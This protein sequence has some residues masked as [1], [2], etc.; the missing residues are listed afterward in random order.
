MIRRY[1]FRISKNGQEYVREPATRI[2]GNGR[3]LNYRVLAETFSHRHNNEA[4]ITTPLFNCINF[5]R[6]PLAFCN[7]GF[8]LSLVNS[9]PLVLRS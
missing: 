7:S 1:N 2:W 5:F 3:R 8:T 4:F 9:F 6:L